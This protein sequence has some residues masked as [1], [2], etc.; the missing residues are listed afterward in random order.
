[1][2]LYNF[3][4]NIYISP[5]RFL[6]LRFEEVVKSLELNVVRFFLFVPQNGA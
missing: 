3:V 5:Q 2:W 1:M 4:L 6:P